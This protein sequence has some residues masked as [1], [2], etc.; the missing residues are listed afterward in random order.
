MK[1]VLAGILLALATPLV[2]A[3]P[4]VHTALARLDAQIS[5][6]P[7][8]Q[9]LYIRRAALH[10]QARHWQAAQ[11]D[12]DTARTLGDSR[13]ADLQQGELLLA[14][15]AVKPAVQALNRYLALHTDHPQAL[16]LRARA[17]ALLGDLPASRK[18]Y[19]RHLDHSAAPHPGD[20]VAFSRILVEMGRPDE[21]MRVLEDNL[22][23]SGE[24]PQLLRA[25]M[26]IAHGR[27]RVRLG[28]RL[29]EALGQTPTWALD[30]A[31][32]YEHAGRAEDARALLRRAEA[33]LAGQRQTPARRA[34]RD[35]I[36]E[37]LESLDPLAGVAPC[38]GGPG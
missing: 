20:A 27:T 28:E 11:Q 5:S 23:R 10:T 14:R 16:L 22:R 19:A 25:A 1:G 26:A 13:E 3:H 33:Q 17:H 2:T 8:R 35:R 36:L 18:D 34:L 15:N 24:Q 4:G 37:Q 31:D 9:A 6:Q 29:G 38:S 21:A 7:H 32:I 30:M 12:L